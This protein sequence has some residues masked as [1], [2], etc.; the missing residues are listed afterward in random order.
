MFSCPG[1]KFCGTPAAGISHI[2]S[3]SPGHLGGRFFFVQRRL[4]RP[5]AVKRPAPGPQH[6]SGSSIRMVFD[7]VKVHFCSSILWLL[8]DILSSDALSCTLLMMPYHAVLGPPSQAHIFFSRAEH[9]IRAPQTSH[10]AHL[11]QTAQQI[12]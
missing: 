1:E 8:G 2:V 9:R 5:G 4:L 11:P 10:I 6:R 12:C 7:P 3:F